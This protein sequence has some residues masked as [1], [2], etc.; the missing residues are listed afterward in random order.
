[1]REALSVEKLTSGPIF[2]ARTVSLCSQI[3]A[4]AVKRTHRIETCSCCANLIHTA[5]VSGSAFVLS[6]HNISILTQLRSKSEIHT[7]HYAGSLFDQS[8]GRFQA[9]V[10]LFQEVTQ[11]KK[12]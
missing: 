10:A 12:M 4:D 2:N 5:L 7:H 3:F 9:L 6:S 1:M 11:C 8:S